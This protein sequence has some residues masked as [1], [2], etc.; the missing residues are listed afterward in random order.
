MNNYV[1]INRDNIWPATACIVL[2]MVGFFGMAYFGLFNTTIEYNWIYIPE[3]ILSLAFLVLAMYGL[4]YLLGGNTVGIAWAK[5]WGLLLLGAMVLGY[6]GH[7][8]I[9]SWQP[10]LPA[11]AF[12]VLCF[13]GGYFPN[14]DLRAGLRNMFTVLGMFVAVAIIYI[15]FHL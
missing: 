7:T 11:I 9:P 8:Y 3:Q 13:C 6:V 12:T 14:H 5:F 4:G 2:G 1:V 10:F 15:L